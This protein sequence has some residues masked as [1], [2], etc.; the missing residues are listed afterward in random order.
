[1]IKKLKFLGVGLVL[2]V[3]LMPAVMARSLNPE[4]IIFIEFN[5]KDD[6]ITVNDDFLSMAWNK[7]FVAED[8]YIDDDDLVKYCIEDGFYEVLIWAPTGFDSDTWDDFVW[9]NT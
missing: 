1:M 8:I 4:K 7:Y 9:S 2:L 5:Y 6:A 3:L